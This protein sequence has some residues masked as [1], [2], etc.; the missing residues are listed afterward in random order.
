METV[1]KLRTLSSSI[2][3]VISI[4]IISSHNKPGDL[5]ISLS[6]VSYSSKLSKRGLWESRFIVDQSEKYRWVWDLGL[7]SEVGGR[8][9]CRPEPLDQWEMT[10]SRGKWCQD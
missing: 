3:M 7:A 9:S 4:F 8:E 5:N 10:L 6:S 1:W 2:W